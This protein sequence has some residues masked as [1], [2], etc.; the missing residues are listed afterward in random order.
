MNRKI[1]FEDGEDVDKALSVVEA[2]EMV[3]HEDAG[4]IVEGA[5]SEDVEETGEEALSED[6][7]G[8]VEEA[9]SVDVEVGMACSEDE[10][11][12]VEEALSEVVGVEVARSVDVGV[13]IARSVDV[14]VIVE[15]VLSEDEDKVPSV[16]REEV[17]MA[18]LSGDVEEEVDLEAVEE[19][20]VISP[21]VQMM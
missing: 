14:V 6:V 3:C 7:V 21:K 4:E 19:I 12:I 10:E 8:I 5:P 11:E 13:E 9:L 2:V 15:E 18:A 1:V 17:A 20:P 16:D